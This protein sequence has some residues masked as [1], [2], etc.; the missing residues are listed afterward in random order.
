MI[1]Y[2]DLCAALARHAAR[3]RG[4]AAGGDEQLANEAPTAEHAMPPVQDEPSNEI[5][6]GDV[7]DEESSVS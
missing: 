6:L 5:E 2:E 4:E 7:V 3:A 1:S